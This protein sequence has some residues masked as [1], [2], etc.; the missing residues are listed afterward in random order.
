MA[1]PGKIKQ[2]GQHLLIGLSG[3]ELSDE[4]KRILSDLS[5]I[6]IVF[7]LKNFRYDLPYEDWVENFG[8]LLT[9]VREYSE[10]SAML[11]TLDH[12]GGRVL[13]TPPPLTRFPHALLYGTQSQEVAKATG[14]ELKS[15]GINVSWSPDA[16]IFS[17]PKNP[18]IGAR[19]F[20]AEPEL[21]GVRARDYLEGLREAGIV[22]CA[23][24]F[25]GHGDT[26]TDSHLEL[27]VLD[28]TLEQ[29]RQRELIPFQT[30]IAAEVPMVMTAHILF[31][32][33]D[34][35]VPATLSQLILTDLLRSELGYQGVIVSDDLDMNAVAKMYGVPGTVARTFHAGCDLLMVSRNLPASAIARTYAI[36]QDFVDSIENGTLS[37]AIVTAASDRIQKLVEQTPQYH[38]QCLSQET[39][40]HHSQLAIACS[41]RK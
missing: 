10:R 33:I 37:E 40:L 19:A 2:F 11:M 9:Q 17:N 18:I 12:E 23:K 4:D 30:L 22:G 14:I 8:N 20:A 24:H 21:A 1:T 27:P 13:R 25:P 31:P 35:D 34:P 7:Y 38:V 41:Y 5:P 28:L 26:T 15:I 36:A 6:G 39:L 3:T 16:D 29:L 32:Q